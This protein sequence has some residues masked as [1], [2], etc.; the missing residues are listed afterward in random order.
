MVAGLSAPR[1][2]APAV[3]RMAGVPLTYLGTLE[4]GQAA[5]AVVLCNDGSSGEIT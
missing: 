3:S 5:V 4:E 2:M 1:L